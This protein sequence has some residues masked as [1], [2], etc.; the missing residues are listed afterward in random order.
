LLPHLRE[1][2]TTEMLEKTRKDPGRSENMYIKLLA[3]LLRRMYVAMRS[4]ETVGITSGDRSDTVWGLRSENG[5]GCFGALLPNEKRAVMWAA[6]ITFC[7]HAP[8]QKTR[9]P[10][11]KLRIAGNSKE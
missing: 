7:P 5:C 10:R 1:N 8:P 4:Q 11:G 9:R 3:N 6:K 2:A